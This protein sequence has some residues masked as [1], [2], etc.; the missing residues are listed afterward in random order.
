LEAFQQKYPWIKEG[1]KFSFA[2]GTPKPL[3]GL[4][5][6]EVYSHDF[7]DAVFVADGFFYKSKD[8]STVQ[9]SADTQIR[10]V[11]AEGKEHN[12][13][14]NFDFLIDEIDELGIEQVT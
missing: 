9:M 4:Y 2:K 7:T 10:R 14:V 13:K 8:G 3:E 11:G 5:V 1:A 6:E 12:S